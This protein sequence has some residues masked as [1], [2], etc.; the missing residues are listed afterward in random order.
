MVKLLPSFNLNRN[1]KATNGRTTKT[2][3]PQQGDRLPEQSSSIDSN[4]S[5]PDLLGD[6]R[7]GGGLAKVHRRESLSASKSLGT[8]NSQHDTEIPL[9]LRRRYRGFSTSIS[10]LFLDEQVVCSAVACCG[11]LAS[12][13]TE[14]LL[15]MRNTRRGVADQVLFSSSNILSISFL[16]TVIGL[17]LTYLIWGSHS[18]NSSSVTDT[19]RHLNQDPSNGKLMGFVQIRMYHKYIW[20]PIILLFTHEPHHRDVST[21]FTKRF[22]YYENQTQ[23]NFPV[24]LRVFIF[25][26]FLFILGILGR[27]RRLHVRYDM[28]KTRLQEDKMIQQA[29]NTMDRTSYLQDI[30]TASQGACSHTLIGCY[31]V[32][33]KESSRSTDDSYEENVSERCFSIISCLCCGCFFQRWIQCFSCC[34]LAQEAREARLLVPPRMQRID[35]IT[36]QPFD[37]YYKDIYTLRRGWKGLHRPIQGWKT[38]FRAL[39]ALSN[40]LLIVFSVGV[41]VVTLAMMFNPIFSFTLGDAFVIMFTFGQSFLVLGMFYINSCVTFGLYFYKSNQL[42]LIIRHRSWYFSQE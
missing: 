33:Q 27:Q 15:E 35:L 31:P 4:R 8:D 30:E 37:D 6:E 16:L 2:N 13:R 29:S 40:G 10:A 38:H 18:N 41:T 5:G 21:P 1:G 39:S 32:D 7:S 28:I 22:L 23:S 42:M 3:H 9:H 20:D 19:Y 34:A 17:S 36:N 12:R 14:H 11:I 24:F 26:V 25:I